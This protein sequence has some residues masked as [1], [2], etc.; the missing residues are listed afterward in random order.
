MKTT[1]SGLS[2]SFAAKPTGTISRIPSPHASI[3]SEFTEGKRDK[4]TLQE[5]EKDLRSLFENMLDGYARCQMIYESNCPR[6]FLYLEVNRAFESL[7][8]LRNVV[9]KR[10]SEVIPGIKETNPELFE[11]Y[12]RVASTGVPEKIETYIESLRIWLSIAV[13]SPEKGQ[14]VAVFDNISERKYAEQAMRRRAEEL[15]ALQATVLDITASHSVSEIL[16]SIVERAVRLLNAS[17]GGL[18]LCDPERQEARCLVSYNTPEDYSGTVLRYGEGAAG[19]VAQTGEPLLINDYRAWLGR[20]SVFETT[21]PFEAIISAPMLWKGQVT[22]VIHALRHAQEQSFTQADL[23]LLVLFANHASIAVENARLF[24]GLQLELAERKRV[25]TV[26]NQRAR[27]LE[28]LYQTS[29]EVNSQVGG[30]DLLGAIVKRAA[31]LT[32][33][34]GGGLYLMEPD[35]ETLKLVVAHNLPKQ[36]VG[37]TLSPGEGLAGKVAQSGKT[38]FVEDYQ[39]WEGRASTYSGIPF[40]RVLSIP[41]IVR[42]KVIGAIN[43][44]DLTHPGVFSK[45]EIRVVELFADQ[46]ALAISNAQLY[47]SAQDELARRKEL[48]QN[49]V[50]ELQF[51]QTIFTASPLGIAAYR[52]SGECI[53]ANNT[54]A[55]IIGTTKEQAL[56]QNF[57]RLDSWKNSGLLDAADR[58]LASLTPNRLEIHTVS[59][60]G[61]EVSLDCRLVPFA[62]HGQPHL[63]AIFDDV[64][65]RKEAEGKIQ[66]HLAHLTAVSEIDQMIASSLDLR[67]SLSMLLAHVTKELGVDAADVLLLDPVSQELVYA[68]GIG[69]RTTALQDTHLPL[70]QGYAGM[71]GL[72]Q[73]TIH[74]SNLRTRHTDF[75]SYQSFHSEGFDTYF[76]VPLIAKGELKG[77]LEIFQR[78][79]FVPDSEWLDFLN[80]L[81]RQAAIAIDNAGLFNDLQR[82]NTE[83]AIAYDAT[84]EGWSR[85]L[86]LRDKET[87]GHTQRV[88]EMTLRLARAFGLTEEQLVHV[89]RGAMLHDIGKMGIP[90]TILLKPGSLS[91][92]EWVVMKKHPTFA[93]ELISSIRY[94]KPA[95]DIPWCHHEKWDGTGYPRGLK[96]DHI[97]LVARI[98]AVVDV[99]DALISD[100]PYR[101]GWTYEEALEYIQSQAGTHFDP[102]VVELF[103]NEDLRP[104]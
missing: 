102:K 40:R 46:A 2:K 32:G 91:D 13:Y 9:G 49:I 58:A 27:E 59:S 36:Y 42:D 24:D 43:V 38:M 95:I 76:G 4:Q 82:S 11:V 83:L 55:E 97:P 34:D 30:D 78:T 41:L 54:L 86:D 74:V 87:E 12:G 10:V 28:S 80:T 101:K 61:K 35:G 81:A 57:R 22:G 31:S 37:L 47:K 26:L 98:F 70:G 33:V 7:T 104:G 52:D 18:Y 8:G 21:Q 60:F 89:R 44:S 25:E 3:R 1:P 90:D 50:D 51:N 48:Q 68:A 71:A 17:G 77:V 75:P 16:P 15:A 19:L 39:A 94:L 84:I 67:F 63:M 64:S 14:F 56:K 88:T 20:A 99:W 100:R 85:A 53:I 45:E 29:L 79:T 92:E 93:N 103:L 5:S 73:Q 66:R 96:G 72:E 62:L 6:D 65:E 69:F 23:Q